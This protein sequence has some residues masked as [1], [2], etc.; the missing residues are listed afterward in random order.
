PG[1]F[2]KCSIVGERYENIFVLPRYL[3]KRDDILFTVNDNHLK[4]KK[5]NV[6]RK[7]EDEIYINK[8][9]APGDK[10]IF[11]PLPGAIEGMELTI[12]LNGK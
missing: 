2:V 7:F 3:L 12:K 6:L 5:V 10:I 1:T 4:M 8:G 11:S 9:L